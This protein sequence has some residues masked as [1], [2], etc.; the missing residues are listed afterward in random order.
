MSKNSRR[1]TSALLDELMGK[2]R[3]APLNKTGKFRFHWSD[4]NFCQHYLCGWCPIREFDGTKV[5][6]GS[7][8]FEHN[9]IAKVQF[10]KEPWK[11]QKY[12]YDRYKQLLLKI[13]SELEFRDRRANDILLQQLTTAPT[14]LTSKVKAP[15]TADERALHNVEEKIPEMLKKV[16][17]L[18]EQGE[19]EKSQNIM[20][21]IDLLKQVA[22]DLKGKIL[23]KRTSMG[24][25]RLYSN[26]KVCTVCGGL[27]DQGEQALY[28]HNVGIIHLGFIQYHAEL[29]KINKL[30]ERHKD[31]HVEPEESDSRRR[32]R[33]RSRSYDDDG[34]SESSKSSYSSGSRSSSREREREF[35][36]LQPQ[37]ERSE[38]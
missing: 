33:S 8:P 21:Q 13:K 6:L 34:S 36:N 27:Q 19:V 5:S 26:F 37:Q 4:R 15:Q 23:A 17:R 31:E 2:S 20:A 18:G 3:N 29:E 25:A 28:D 16:E 11:T 35:P 30:Y 14:T 24:N 38:F 1:K 32:R 9:E 12:T 10:Q 7:C 22:Q